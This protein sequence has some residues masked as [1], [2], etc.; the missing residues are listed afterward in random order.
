[1]LVTE[2]E[3]VPPPGLLRRGDSGVTGVV[4][5]RN[6]AAAQAEDIFAGRDAR[7]A[8]ARGAENVDHFPLQRPVAGIHVDL[9]AAKRDRP[10]HSGAEVEERR[11]VEYPGV[12]QREGPG[13]R[14]VGSDRLH[15]AKPAR[16]DRTEVI[17]SEGR[18]SGV[19]GVP[20]LVEA[21]G[22]AVVALGSGH[23]A[24]VIAVVAGSGQRRAIRLRVVSQI[25][26]GKG[27]EAR[28]RNEFS[29]ERV[30]ADAR[31]LGL[32]GEWIE[33]LD[34]HAPV[35]QALREVTLPLEH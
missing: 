34:G 22:P 29:G 9:L 19:A 28:L 8:I 31:T 6:L 15:G 33:D 2:L 3:G 18:V 14:P 20:V 24:D 5:R 17:L 21:A 7:H 26:L 27:V 32:P 4:R 10:D 13:R 30:T 11:R 23:R 35:E 16:A 25:D 12:I 1:M